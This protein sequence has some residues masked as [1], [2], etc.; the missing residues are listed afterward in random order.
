MQYYHISYLSNIL[1]IKESCR[2]LLPICFFFS[3]AHSETERPSRVQIVML[4]KFIAIWELIIEEVMLL[5][6]DL[7]KIKNRKCKHCWQ[8]L[9]KEKKSDLYWRCIP[10]LL[11]PG[12]LWNSCELACILQYLPKNTSCVLLFDM[13]G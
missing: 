2:V 6:S 3:S 9:I 8:R 7:F 4:L 11:Q 10:M 5:F 12:G 13:D 1:N